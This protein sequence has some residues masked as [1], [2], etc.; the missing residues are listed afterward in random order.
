MTVGIVTRGWNIVFP[1]DYCT[2]V[3]EIA[4]L[5]GF[6]VTKTPDYS[7]YRVGHSME[8]MVCMKK[9]LAKKE[10]LAI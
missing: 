1:G 7:H 10:E 4:Y 3:S 9:Q 5:F 2:S 6:A 8:I